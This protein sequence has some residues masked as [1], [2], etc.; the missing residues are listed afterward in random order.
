M[1]FDSCVKRDDDDFSFDFHYLLD[2]RTFI[3]FPDMINF[4][5]AT[6]FCLVL[7]YVLMDHPFF[8]FRLALVLRVSIRIVC[9]DVYNRFDSVNS[10]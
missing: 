6:P 5:R 7:V 4:Y 2:G 8:F 3:E 1:L 9:T 10:G